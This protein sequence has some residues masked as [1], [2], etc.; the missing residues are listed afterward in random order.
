MRFSTYNTKIVHKKGKYHFV[1]DSLSRMYGVDLIDIDSFSESNDEKYNDIV[2]RCIKKPDKFVDEKYIFKNDTLYRIV[3]GDAKGNPILRIYVPKDRT[4]TALH[5]CH[6]AIT[7]A[8]GGLSK[9]MYRLKQYYYWPHMFD[10]TR[11]HINY[12]TE[13]KEVKQANYNLIPGMGKQRIAHDPW[14]MIA[15]DFIGPFTGSSNQN[16]WILTI[17]DCFSKYTI[18]HPCKEASAA[19]V[20]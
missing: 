18:V 3:N 19:I 17:V 16:K 9:T 10:N 4:S 13:C 1:P 2:K 20:N 5:D 7:A 15:I 11:N 6:S 12:C 8:H 14:S